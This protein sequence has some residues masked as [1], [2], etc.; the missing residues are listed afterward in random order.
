MKLKMCLRGLF[1][2]ALAT[3]LMSSCSFSAK[4]Y[5]V[6][7]PLSFVKE[8]AVKIDEDI[9]L[10]QDTSSAEY[11]KIKLSEGLHNV[12]INGEVT[13]VNITRSG[14]LNLAKEVFVVLPIEYRIEESS[15]EDHAGATIP[16]ILDSTLFYYQ[17]PTSTDT[18]MTDAK[19]D[20]LMT[21][22]ITKNERAYSRNNTKYELNK[23]P[24]NTFFIEKSWNY[25]LTQDPPE[26]V[27]EFMS[28]NSD[29]T[30]FYRW[31]VVTSNYAYLYALLGLNYLTEKIR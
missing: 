20:R 14:I 24:A 16:I 2:C 13:E 6:E 22:A 18:V 29:Q 8:N 30:V 28:D 5:D 31:Q 19:Y 21:Q 17:S 3:A 10:S 9:N 11:G 23:I 26:T 7:F 15:T 25:G 1:L 27:Q 12:S 4:E